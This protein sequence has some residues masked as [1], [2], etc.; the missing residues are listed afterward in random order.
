ML[1][2]HLCSQC[3]GLA[4][5]SGYPADIRDVI[6][7]NREQS[8][9]FVAQ[10]TQDKSPSEKA[11]GIHGQAPSAMVISQ[12]RGSGGYGQHSPS[13]FSVVWL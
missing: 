1:G 9:P 13:C 11:T 10:G 8:G 6:V 5:Q 12:D 3:P 4:G 7:E 2:H